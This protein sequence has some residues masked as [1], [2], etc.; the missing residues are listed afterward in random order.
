MTLEIVCTVV[1][2]VIERHA[3]GMRFLQGVASVY[4]RSRS[5]RGLTKSETV[6]GASSE[7]QAW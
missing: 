4:W 7:R 3:V 2:Q 1:L 5:A 6:E